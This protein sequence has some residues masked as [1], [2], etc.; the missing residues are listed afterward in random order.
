[1]Q[2]LEQRKWQLAILFQRCG[3][4]EMRTASVADEGVGQDPKHPFGKRLAVFELVE[5]APGLDRCL[6]HQVFGIGLVAGEAQ[7]DTIKTAQ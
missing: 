4:L 3:V 2:L 5:F 7:G 1:M 6:R